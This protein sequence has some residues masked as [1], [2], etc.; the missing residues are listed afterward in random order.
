MS[1]E[2]IKK[3]IEVFKYKHLPRLQKM[4]RYYNNDADILNRTFA[5]TTKPNHK[6]PNSFADYISNISTNYFIGKPVTY[7]ATDESLLADLNN[8]FKYND[9]QTTNNTIAL[10]QSIYGYGL[11]IIYLDNNSD[12]RFT[13]VEVEN[14]ILIFDNTLENNLIYA[15]RF[16]EEMDILTNKTKLFVELY[17]ELDIKYFVDIDGV[18]VLQETREHYFKNVPVNIYCNNIDKNGDFEKVISLIDAYNLAVSDSANERESF[19]EAYLVFKNSGLDDKKIIKM[20]ETRNIVIQDSGEDSGADVSFLVK[21]GNPTE[22]ETNKQRIENDI[23]KFTFVNNMAGDAQKSHTSSAGAQLG[24]LGLE[25]IM[26]RKEAFFRFGLTRRIEIICELLNI[27]GNNYNFRDVSIQ[28]T[29]NIPIDNNLVADTVSK[30]RGLVSDETLWGMLP[31]IQ[32]IEVERERLAKQN[33]LNSYNNIFTDMLN[34]DTE[35]A[36]NE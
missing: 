22:A 23:H 27:K 6:I 21:N 28:F 10:N 5:D 11:E 19:N 18:L 20:K 30:L 2:R 17:S 34:S 13:P 32:D 33:E 9:E 31:M 26:A 15:I 7:N 8:I 25:Q 3:Y 29:K 1:T 36:N 24:L 16:F 12:L 14:T 35:G 4:K